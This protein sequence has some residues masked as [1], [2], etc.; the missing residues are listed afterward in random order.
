M[1]VISIVF[2]ILLIT[3]IQVHAQYADTS[4]IDKKK[5]RSLMITAGAVYSISI[6]GMYELW[7]KDS[8]KTSFHFFNDSKGW[9]QVDKLGH[10]YSTFY[11]SYGSSKGLQWTGMSKAKSDLWGSL[12][13]FAIMLPI[14]IMDGFVVDYGASAYD[15]AANALGSGF[16]LGQSRL[17]NEIRIQPKFSFQ[18]TEFPA[19]RED[20]VLGDGFVSELLKDYN[21]QT[22]WLSFHVDRFIR[23]PKWLNLAV[24]YGANGMVYAEDDKNEAAGYHAYRQYYLGLD[25]D[26]SHL[27]T[28][29][30]ALNTLLFVVGMV[31][32]PA[33]AVQFSEKGTSFNFFQF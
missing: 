21:G 8:E 22:Y 33:P 2:S 16:Y 17:W 32:L 27:K 9:K 28:R 24:G 3:S 10:F 30:K 11:L 12:A 18:R 1:K 23:F 6:V 26:L 20:D 4:S 15:L 31:K 14:E 7:Y 19:L 13:G 29:S 5:F 25:L